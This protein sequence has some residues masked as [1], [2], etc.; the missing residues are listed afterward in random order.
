MTALH[1]TVS[2]IDRFTEQT[3]RLLAWL[4]LAMAILAG[5]VVLLRYGFG[6]GSV[7]MQELV[8]YM[9]ASLFMLGTAF[10]L[11]RGGHVRV[12]IFYRRLSRR[13]R[14]WVN[15]IGAL[16]FL[17]PFCVFLLGV[18]L[19]FVAAAWSVREGSPDPGGIQAV[20]LLKTLIPLLAVNLMLQGTAETLRNLLFLIE[21]SD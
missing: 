14:A 12:D 7:A 9:H 18:S 2:I 3:G 6:V 5:M 21:D 13:A 15:C 8:T 1:N 11:K 10:A 20:F 16:L 17:L 4:C 19:Q